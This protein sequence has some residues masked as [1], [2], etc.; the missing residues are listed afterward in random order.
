VRNAILS[1]KARGRTKRF[2]VT[3]RR[4]V[5]FLVPGKNIV[6]GG[7][8]SI[9]SIASETKVLLAK[10]GVSIAICTAFFEPRILRYTKF[11]N[12]IDILALAD[13]LPRFP[14]GADVLVHLPEL[15]AQ[16]YAADCLFVYR[17]RPDL[18][19]QFN[20]LLQ[21]IDRLPEK[22]VIEELASIGK[23]TASTA[24]KAYATDDTAR[25]IGCPVHFLS[26]WVS[27]ELYERIGY[28]R[29]NKIVMIS[30]DRNPDREKI[31]R[32]IAKSLPDH[33]IVE[34]RNVTYRKY[35]E[36]AKGAKFSFTFGEGLDAYF[37]ETIFSGGVAMA[38]FNDRFFTEEY[39]ALDGVFSDGESAIRNVGKFLKMA[40]NA[41]S[42]QAIATRQYNV[43]AKNYLRAEYLYNV[44]KYYEKYFS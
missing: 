11:D 35:R 4:F 26:V 31:I 27:P 3:N 40:D 34:I 6:N 14:S 2:N 9:F 36:I 25:R 18:R 7:V 5:L 43:A 12:D 28:S 38:I 17:T 13:L 16:K 15:F 33:R 37:I 22:R 32:E 42:Y 29:K 30:P 23:V 19:W 44:K 41:G 21:N 39:K 24:H 20:I 8:M 10:S 1:I